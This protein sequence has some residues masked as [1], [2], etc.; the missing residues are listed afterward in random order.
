M[1]A[2][3]IK[4]AT[5]RCL[6]T[7]ILLISAVSILFFIYQKNREFNDRSAKMRD[8]FLLASRKT[9]AQAVDDAIGFMSYAANG[10]AGETSAPSP[11]PTKDSV[12][13]ASTA[14]GVSASPNGKTASPSM[15]EVFNRLSSFSFCKLNNGGTV[16]AI[17]RS[18][19]IVTHPE[20]GNVGT[21]LSEFKDILGGFP[22]GNIIE[23]SLESE[24]GFANY[25]TYD[26]AKGE[27]VKTLVCWRAFKRWDLIVCAEMP[28]NKLEGMIE[29]EKSE[30][31]R[32]LIADT[33]YLGLITVAAVAVAIMWYSRFS[34]N[35]QSQFTLL[36]DY[37]KKPFGKKEP[38]AQTE[39]EFDELRFI[40]E[41]TL[42]MD[43]AIHKLN[44]ELEKT[45]EKVK[46]TA[47]NSEVNSQAKSCFF[48]NI[49]HEIRTRLNGVMGMTDFLAETKLGDDQ[50]KFLDTIKGSCDS[51]LGLLGDINDYSTIETG[52]LTINEKPFDLIKII[53]DTTESVRDKAVA[54]GVTLNLNVA[55]ETP[56]HVEGDHARLGQVFSTLLS[57]AIRFT[58]EGSVDF[59]VKPL[60]KEG[61]VIPIQFRFK[62]TGPG[63]S[64]EKLAVLFDFTQGDDNL[65]RKF[66]GVALGLT[67]CKHLVDMMGGKIT[68]ESDKD[69]GTCV[70][71]VLPMRPSSEAEVNRAQRGQTVIDLD[72]TAI[73]FK[74]TPSEKTFRVL[75]AEDD[76]INQSVAKTYLKRMGC[77]VD[78]AHN[79]QEAVSKFKRGP[80]DLI[81]MDCEMPEMDGMTAVN[82]IRKI[83][84][85]G[86]KR[87]PIIALTANALKGD[88]TACLNAGMDGHLP[89]PI[90]GPVI[91]RLLSQ[92]LT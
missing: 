84:A 6:L 87:T 42:Q 65:S 54:K 2:K 83:E 55:D 57:N 72:K 3:S 50:R 79:G 51:L 30:L 73:D 71:I 91:E 62:D 9:L 28:L 46:E 33:I 18:G 35:L 11:S 14:N 66:G 23:K 4:S 27:F 26:E 61:D 47:I 67:V 70:E 16:F 12:P 74:S 24:S 80:Y 7:T 86:D 5:L 52:K 64:K 60:E 31:R 22:F 21:D 85:G 39:F 90:N 13:R 89:K 76:P 59:D 38:I 69:A 78:L 44:E 68:A 92:Y 32:D 75:L 56:K 34:Q 37:L 20:P 36:I 48:A 40:A 82:I 77:D 8:N 25:K 19:K 17:D 29:A 49:S 81:L 15:R 58:K 41:S 43:R 1:S 10:A 63:I 88:K 53:D 45:L